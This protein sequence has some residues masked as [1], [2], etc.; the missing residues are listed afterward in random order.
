M[1]FG[2][3]CLLQR[4]PIGRGSG[5]GP[6][7]YARIPLWRK[8]HVSSSSNTQPKRGPP[9]LGG[10]CELV[11]GMKL[12]T[13]AVTR[14]VIKASLLRDRLLAE[15]LHPSGP[16]TAS[17]VTQWGGEGSLR[18]EVPEGEVDDAVKVMLACGYEGLLA[19]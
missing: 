15:G 17:L 8:L 13:I 1:R 18:I 12:V 7:R 19:R 3:G 10:F 6:V 16:S 5:D 11:D 14:N 2:R 4:T 9:A